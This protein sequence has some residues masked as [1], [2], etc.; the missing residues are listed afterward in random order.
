M[1]FRIVLLI[2]FFLIVNA[3]YACTCIGKRSIKQEIKNTDVI[4][5]GNILSK[6]VFSIKT[7]F[8]PEEFYIKKVEYLVKVKISLKGN[9]VNDT[10][11]IITGVG[12]GDC[13]VE[14]SLN[15]DYIIYGNYNNKYSEDGATVEKF[16]STD[17]CSRTKIFDECELKKI[18][19]IQ[20]RLPPSTKSKVAYQIYC[21]Y[22]TGTPGYAKSSR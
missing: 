3:G 7:D 21:P 18:K 4:L 14:F 6:R 12:N 11:R 22:K 10:I 2:V 8:V 13:G 19:R 20:K 1:K 5:V 15:H 9:I 17:I 16:I